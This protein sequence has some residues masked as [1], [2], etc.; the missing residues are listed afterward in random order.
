MHTAQGAVWAA[1]I[2]MPVGLGK[3][4]MKLH[5]VVRPKQA[6]RSKVDDILAVPPRD[7][8][9]FQRVREQSV[10]GVHVHRHQQMVEA[11]HARHLRVREPAYKRTGGGGGGGWGES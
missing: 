4:S 9:E 5:N 2:A 3:D 1:Y 6:G 8:F 7:I 10:G 11:I